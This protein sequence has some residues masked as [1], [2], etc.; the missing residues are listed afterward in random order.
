MKLKEWNWDNQQFEQ[1]EQP[2]EI[3]KPFMEFVLLNKQWPEQLELMYQRFLALKR[4][5]TDWHNARALEEA[6]ADALRCTA[7]TS[8]GERCKRDATEG[9]FCEGHT[10]LVAA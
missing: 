10:E 2:D 5:L 1:V 4:E 9:S 6:A 3:I 7:T 8:S